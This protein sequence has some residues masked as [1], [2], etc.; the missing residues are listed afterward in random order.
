MLGFLRPQIHYDGLTLRM[1]L[2]KNSAYNIIGFAVPTIIAI[3]CLG[4]LSRWLSIEEFGIFIL[5]FAFL[6]YASIFDGGLSR[7][8]TRETALFKDDK[9]EHLKII[10]NA[11]FLIFFFSIFASILMYFF[12][13]NI[14]AYLNVSSL[15]VN[16]VIVSLKILSL[17]IPFYLLNLIWIGYLEGIE[18]FLTVNIQKTIG[19]SLII[20]FPLFFCFFEKKLVFAVLGILVGRIISLIITFIICNEVIIKAKFKFDKSI[21]KRLLKFGGWI[22]ISNIVSPIMVY[23]DKFIVSNV[24]GANKV[25]LYSAPAEGVSRLINLPIALSKALFPKITNA[26]TVEEQKKLEK[27][28]YIVICLFCLPLVLIVFFFAKEI[29]TMWMGEQYGVATENILRILIIGFFFNALAQI[30][31]TILQSKGYSKY[32]AFIHLFE[33]FP[34]LIF[35]YFATKNYGIIGAAG[36]WSIRVIL[37]LFLLVFF[38]FRLRNIKI[39]LD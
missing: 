2:I 9:Y 10:A 12:S 32:T 8:V 33:V 31:Y 6:G 18:N 29:M 4:I 30:P 13:K 20:L 25:A 5:S 28:S 1:S 22:T 38:C 37:D 19:N 23:M 7:A 14:V 36:V 17:A 26:N 35:V 34:Y 21:V 16:N 39:K 15:Y 11:N 24:L 27:F 3:P